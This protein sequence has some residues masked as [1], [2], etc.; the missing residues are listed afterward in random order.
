[1]FSEIDLGGAIQKKEEK[2]NQNEIEMKSKI[3]KLEG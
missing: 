1:M 2:V 3:D